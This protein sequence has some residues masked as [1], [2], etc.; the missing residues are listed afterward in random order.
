[1]VQ[2]NPALTL[3]AGIVALAFATAC[4]L[5]STQASF[6]ATHPMELGAGRP[7]CTSC[8]PDE[9]MTDHVRSYAAYDHTTDFILAHGHLALLDNNVCASCHSPRFCA[10]CHSDK[11]VLKP[12]ARHGNRPDM[13]SPHKGDYL[14]RHRIE[15]KIDPTACYKCHGRANNDRCRAC[16]R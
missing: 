7:S 11:A 2:K 13:V 10:D 1:M 14:T 15:G 5:V 12:A 9:P 6:T 16:H 3:A 8:H 4:I